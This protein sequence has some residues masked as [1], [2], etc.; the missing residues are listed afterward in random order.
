MLNAFTAPEEDYIKSETPTTVNLFQLL[1]AI[2]AK[3]S[4]RVNPLQLLNA[5]R[6]ETHKGL[7]YVDLAMGRK[8][9]V[10]L[11]D[12][13]AT[14]NFVSTRETVKLGLKLSKDD[15]KLKVVNKKA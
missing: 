1:H 4:T 9:F 15:N 11:V 12:I 6:A 14:H 3:T 7:M 2:R 8:K 13:R 10:A 5:I